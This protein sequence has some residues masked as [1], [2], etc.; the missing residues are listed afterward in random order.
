MDSTEQF[1]IEFLTEPDFSGTLELEQL[2]KSFGLTDT[3]INSFVGKHNTL[4][5]FHNMLISFSIFTEN[6]YTIETLKIIERCEIEQL[7]KQPFL[8]ERTKCVHG[9]NSWRKDLVSIIHLQLEN[10]INYFKISMLQNL[11]LLSGAPVISQPA[12]RTTE[13]TLTRANCTA[14]FLLES[15]PKGIAAIN[16]YRVNQLLTRY[17]K[18]IITHIVVD[19]FKDR[20]SKLTSSELESRATEL[21]LMFPSE[22]KVKLIIRP[23]M[24]SSYY[25]FCSDYLFLAAI[26]IKYLFLPVV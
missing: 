16:K 19:E 18:R 21:H 12:L 26:V 22:P 8:A 23:L 15:S 1:E 5:A 7:I 3:V 10:S 25:L 13:E 6:G 17:D 9:I 11:P 20:F 4:Y 2:L 24:T 14:T